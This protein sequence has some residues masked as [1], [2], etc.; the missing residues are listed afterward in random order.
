MRFVGNR[1][2]GLTKLGGRPHLSK[3][4]E[5]G[6]IA[7]LQLC[8][9]PAIRA[10]SQMALYF[11]LLRQGKLLAPEEPGAHV[12]MPDHGCS[13]YA[14]RNRSW[15]RQRRIRIAPGRALSMTPI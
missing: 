4:A 11:D 3:A 13:P 12:T 9:L 8:C 15:A 5:P 6:A 10:L 2:H 7:T 14:L 1:H